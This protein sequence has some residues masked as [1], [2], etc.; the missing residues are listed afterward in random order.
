MDWGLGE[1]QVDGLI[2]LFRAMD[3]GKV[4]E[5]SDAL[6]MILGRVRDGPV[7]SGAQPK[8]GLI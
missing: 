7:G 3:D 8:K 5:E 4:A 1:W 6:Q 2:E